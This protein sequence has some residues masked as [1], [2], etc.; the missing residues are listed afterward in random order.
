MS[1]WRGDHAKLEAVKAQ[2]V[3]VS[4]DQTYAQRVFK[5]SLGGLPYELLA[6]WMRDTAQA[7]GVLDEKGG[8]ARRSVFVLG[9]DHKLVYQNLEFAAGNRTHYDAVLESVQLH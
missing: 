3:A 1:T 7:Y 2:I 5:A 8:Y 9:T 4:T 6:D